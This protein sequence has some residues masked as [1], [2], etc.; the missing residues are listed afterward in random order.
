MDKKKHSLWHWIVAASVVAPALY[1]ASF[2]PACWLTARQLQNGNYPHHTELRVYWPI[3]ALC[4]LGTTPAW[5]WW[6]MEL[7]VPGGH[8]ICVTT[9]LSGTDTISWPVDHSR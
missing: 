7:G 9:N 5:L 6:W 8:F 4:E 3:G 1:V 2:G